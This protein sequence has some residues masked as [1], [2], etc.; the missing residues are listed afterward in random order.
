[1]IEGESELIFRVGRISVSLRGPP[2]DCVSLQEHIARYFEAPSTSRASDSSSG[3]LLIDPVADSPAS[4]E[5]TPTP[6]RHSVPEETRSDV[7]ASFPP[8][9]ERWSSLAHQL[10]SAQSSGIDRIRRAWVAGQWAS[11]AISGRVSTPAHTPVLSIVLRAPGLEAP[12][13]VG[14]SKAYFDI[15][16][17]PFAR[18]TI[19]HSFPSILEVRVYCDAAGVA[20]PQPQ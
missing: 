9:P 10:H 6:P 18:S 15:V 8:L 12:V 14:T 11:A 19:S 2:R 7:L 5:P 16:G 20:A 3:Y 1:M 4:E 13:L 17:R